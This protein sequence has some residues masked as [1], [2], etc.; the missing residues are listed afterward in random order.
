MKYEWIPEQNRYVLRAESV[1]D[2]RFLSALRDALEHPTG[3]LTVSGAEPLPDRA[4]V[5]GLTPNPVCSLGVVVH[6]A[7]PA[8]MDPNANYKGKDAHRASRPQPVAP[9]NGVGISET[10]ASIVRPKRGQV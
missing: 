4:S 3:K 1:Q 5:S 6:G 7:K 8:H 2:V 10:L 9:T